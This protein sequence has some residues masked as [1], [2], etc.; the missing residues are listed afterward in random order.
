MHK[1]NPVSDKKE[2]K[3]QLLIRIKFQCIKGEKSSR[4]HWAS[5]L[6]GNFSE[7]IFILWDSRDALYFHRS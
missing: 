7:F 2:R 3:K 6:A 5:N 4:I 1:E